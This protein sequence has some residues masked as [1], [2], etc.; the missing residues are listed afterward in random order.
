MDK[1]AAAREK[2]AENWIYSQYKPQ[3]RPNKT[4]VR[5]REKQPKNKYFLT[6][7]QDIEGRCDKF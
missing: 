1:V 2:L 5:G 4:Q 3:V 6:K 7:P